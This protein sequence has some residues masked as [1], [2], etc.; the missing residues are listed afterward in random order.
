MTRKHKPSI[1]AKKRPAA[2][3]SRKPVKAAAA[4]KA[5]APVATVREKDHRPKA[6]ATVRKPHEQPAIAP[7][8]AA[9]RSEH[10]RSESPVATH[11]DTRKARV[12]ARASGSESHN[13]P[14]NGGA[15]NESPAATHN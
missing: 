11:S 9:E 10:G 1:A 8:Q 2:A 6:A 3:D 5:V 7:L 4:E 12:G 14:S 13:G 15:K